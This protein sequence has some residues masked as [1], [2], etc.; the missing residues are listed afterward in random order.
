VAG[1][2][3]TELHGPHPRVAG[4]DRPDHADQR[5]VGRRALLEVRRAGG[6]MNKNWRDMIKPKRLERTKSPSLRR[7]ASSSASRSSVATAP[8]SA[9]RCDASSCRRSTAPPSRR[10]ASGASCTSSRRCR[11]SPRT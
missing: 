9:T 1:G 4:P 6:P 2:R 10:C 3:S 11:A 7:T 8:P 5:E